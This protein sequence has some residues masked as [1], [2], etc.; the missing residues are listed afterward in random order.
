MGLRDEF[1]R[2]IQKKQ[3]EIVELKTTI[4][5]AEAALE[6]WQ[7]SY[8]LLPKE[9]AEAAVE[10]GPSSLRRGSG[11]SKAYN[12]L[13]RNGQVMHIS[14]LLEG[15]GKKSTR[16]NTAGLASSIRAY[17]NRGQIFTKPAP[18]T[19]G[20]VEWGA[21]GNVVP[22]SDAEE[23]TPDIFEFSQRKAVS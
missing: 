18:N 5:M 9:G 23:K 16:S 17:A 6:A 19:Y 15:I 21:S 14:A 8:R 2:K 22:E 11:V 10:T 1:L 13:R 3:A 7:E 20:L 12:V 4:R